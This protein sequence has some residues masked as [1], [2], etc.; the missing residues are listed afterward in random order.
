MVTELADNRQYLAVHLAL[1]RTLNRFVDATERRQP[2]DL[3]NVLGSR[4][5]VF[6]RLLHHHHEGEDHSFFPA[7][8][9]ASPDA[10]A[11]VD[12][13]EAEHHELVPKLDAVDAA[14]E[15]FE[16]QPGTD[17]QRTVHD[18]IK[19]VR[20]L[21]FPHLEIEDAELLPIAA[22]SVDG[23]EWERLG[24]EAFRTLAKHDVPIAAGALDEV[25][26]DL[27][28]SEWPPPPPLPVRVLLALSWRRRYRTFVAP[29]DA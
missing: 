26:Q 5:A 2:S 16:G 11:L 6:A 7:I 19:E 23:K 25:L 29:L 4:W 28:K 15:A 12:R 20:D 1:R 13:L 27:P 17:T 3:T 21:L 9:A 22:Q 8:T 10:K 24:D 18:A 14:V